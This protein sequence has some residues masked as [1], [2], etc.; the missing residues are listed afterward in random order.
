MNTLMKFAAV[1]SIFAASAF[2][3]ESFGGVGVVYK[4]TKSGVEVQDVIPESPIAE[5]KIKAGDVIV[6]IDGASVQGK[7]AREVK[8]ALRGLENK[9]VVLAYV[10][11]G[12]T[13]V[14]TVRRVKL[15]VKRLNSVADAEQPEKKLLAV[16][17]DG[18]VVGNM[19]VSGSDNLEGVYVDGTLISATEDKPQMLAKEGAAKLAFFS[20]NVIRV[21]L[22]TAGAFAVSVVDSNG[23]VV[24]SFTEKNGR[25]GINSIFW[26]G[27]LVPGGRYAIS[28]EHN[29]TVCGVNILLK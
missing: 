1:A 29:G 23:D 19:G 27:S 10:S 2:A 25:A 11:E 18:R 15:S 9:P 5:T 24:R 7:G 26:D 6:A 4:L 28:I 14:E 3:D 20:R 13:L 8:N 21:K 22:E 12:D 17:D 16:L